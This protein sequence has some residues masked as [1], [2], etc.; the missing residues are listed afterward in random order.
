MYIAVVRVRW[1]VAGVD[2]PGPPRDV[3]VTSA[4]DNSVSLSWSA[5]RDDGGSDVTQYVVEKREALRMSWQPAA[6]V[7][8]R[9][10]SATIGGLDQG[11]M[12]VFR[13]SAVNSVGTGPPEELS[14]A[15]APKS[16]HS[17]SK[18]LDFFYPLEVLTH[19]GCR[20]C[21]LGL[22]TNLDHGYRH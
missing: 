2:K 9:T 13:V 6:T 11:V 4:V 1:V 21:K 12:Y 17:E 20:H 16:P 14:K 19:Q 7:S 22:R 18:L 8:A 10:T 5:P 3:H 15:I